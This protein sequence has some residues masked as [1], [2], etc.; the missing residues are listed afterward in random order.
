MVE[1]FSLK[2]AKDVV[3]VT[4]QLRQRLINKNELFSHYNVIECDESYT[5]KTCGYC[6]LINDKLGG[7]IV[8]KCKQENCQ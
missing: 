4:L 6:G 5:C 8:V 2:R 1:I 3:L 7:S